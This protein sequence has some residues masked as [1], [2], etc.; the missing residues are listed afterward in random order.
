MIR[1]FP[2]I[3]S[4]ITGLLCCGAPTWK[5]L[6]TLSTLVDFQTYDSGE[7]SRDTKQNTDIQSQQ[8]TVGPSCIRGNQDANGGSG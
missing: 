1:G 7:I 8:K 4:G 2:M 3:M 5:S 6:T